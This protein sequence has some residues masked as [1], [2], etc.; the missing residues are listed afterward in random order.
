MFLIIVY[1]IVPVYS[2]SSRCL[3]LMINSQFNIIYNTLPC[4][5]LTTIPGYLHPI[6]ITKNKIT[7]QQN[8]NYTYDLSEKYVGP[9]VNSLFAY[10]ISCVII[11]FAIL[12]R[13]WGK[14]N[15]RDK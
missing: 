4:V 10:I 2:S 15:R 3:D 5:K 11:Y 12:I 13:I 9:I 7:Y 1:Y 6:Y 8:A 14:I